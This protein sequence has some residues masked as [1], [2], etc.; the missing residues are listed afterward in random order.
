[1]K[2]IYLA[3]A[4]LL[5]AGAALLVSQRGGVQW[6]GRQADGSYLL[7]T[8]WSVKPAGKQVPL[9]T[10]PMASALTPDGK[11]MFVLNGGYNPPSISVVDTAAMR[12]TSR[13]KVADGWL[14][15]AVAPGGKKIYVGGGAKAA[16]FEFDFDGELKPARTLPTAEQPTNQDFIGDVAVSA[17]GRFLFAAD[18]FHDQVLVFNLSTARLIEKFKTGRRPYRILFHPDGKSFFVS[19]WADGAVGQYDAATGNRLGLIRLGPHTTDMVW[20][21]VK[22]EKPAEGAP[23]KARLFVTAGNTNNVFVVGVGEDKSMRLVETINVALT[24]SHRLG[25]TPSGVAVSADGS[26]LYT[27]C[28]DANTVAVADIR[29]ARSRVLGFLPVGWYPTAARALADGRLVVFNGRGERSYPNPNGP[30][31]ARRAAPSHLGPEAV[32]YVGRIQTGSASV[33]DPFSTEQLETYTKLVYDLSPYRDRNAVD[34]W[35]AGDTWLYTTP[36]QKSP[37]EH[38]IYIVKENRTYDQVFGDLGRGNGDPSL[39]LFDAKS[40][41]NHR[42]LANDFVLFD[43]FYVSAD[44]SADGH[45]WSLAA[46]APDYTQRMWPNSYGGRRKNYDYEG[47][48]PANTPPAGYIWT[49]VQAAGLSMRNYGYFVKNTEKAMPTGQKQITE[50]VDPALRNVTNEKFRNFDMDYPDV[51]RTKVFLDDLAAWE[52]TGRMPNFMI[53]R[54]GNDHTSGT[55]PGKIAPLSAMA[56]ND[57][58][59]GLL[60]EAVSK[61]RFWA[62]TAIFILQDDAQNGPDHVDSHRSPAFVISPYT[63]RGI[64]DSNFY[65][66]ASMLRT[67]G[68]ILGLK[69]MTHYDAAATPMTAAFART[70]NPAPWT[71]EPPRMSLTERNPA[72]SAT[73]ARSQ[74]L[75]FARADAIDDDELNDILWRALKKTEPPAPVRSYFG[76]WSGA[77]RA[78]D[79]DGDGDDR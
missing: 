59:I 41:P 3:V 79:P 35:T 37:I 62:K 4:A 65:N 76:R 29:E 30:N 75:D 1:M 54:I 20:R 70:A 77:R 10:F 50:I 63:R 60:V 26:T 14:G 56:D 9:D 43:N 7:N 48:E 74:R 66:T 34:R 17:D 42:K 19:S 36:A 13:A 24:P 69:P 55:S 68:L 58:A 12:E 40:T 33:I 25:M 27:V 71:A 38:V 2:K 47:G 67:M 51:D 53:L 28:S 61:S 18:L 8:G 15:L 72:N 52:K 16:I 31:P 46:I 21:D 64:I 39:T 22:D 32:Q 73:A 6:A 5:V 78:A 44:V 45:N 11:T 57:Y 49:N 23:W